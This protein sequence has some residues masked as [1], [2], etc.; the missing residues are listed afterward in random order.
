[1]EEPL[2]KIFAVI[3]LAVTVATFSSVDWNVP[4]PWPQISKG[5]TA[6]S[7]DWIQ[8]QLLGLLEARL[9]TLATVQ[10]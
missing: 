4:G 9:M 3:T 6:R 1:M 5:I 2:H 10:R 8:T 7:P